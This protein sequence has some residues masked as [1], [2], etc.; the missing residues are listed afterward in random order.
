MG[1]ATVLDIRQPVA[2][3][4]FAILHFLT[5]D[6]GPYDVVKALT[7]ELVPGSALAISHTTGDDT[8]EDRAAAAEKVYQQASAPAV[9]RTRD[10]ILRFFD[11]LTLV[12]PGLTDINHWPTEAATPAV[13]TV[14]YGGVALKPS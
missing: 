9:P 14:F 10:D 11:G 1:A 2:V 7:R 13:P 5:D 6:D 3:L 8:P 4:L 12:P